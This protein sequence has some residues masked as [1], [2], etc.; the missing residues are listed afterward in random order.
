MPT[1]IK[2]CAFDI[3]TRGK[4]PEFVSGALV[5][6]AGQDYFTDA[7]AMIESLRSYAR[8]GYTL[9][10]HNAEYDV[11]VLLWGYGEDVR[12]D[13][14]NGYYTA[15]YWKYGAGRRRAAIWD[16]YR[17]AAGLPLQSL[18][19]AIGIRKY[20][21]PKRLL[22]PDDVRQDWMCQTHGAPGC[23]I[24]YNI[25]DTEIVWGYMNMLREWLGG[26]GVPLKKSLPSI[27]ME[28]WQLWNPHEQQTIR[29]RQLKQL[30]RASYHGGRCEVY[31]YGS[32][33]LPNTYDIRRYYG[34]LLLNVQ[35]PDIG[36]LRYV[37][38]YRG[39]IDRLGAEGVID[40]TVRIPAQHI[41]P[42]PVVSEQRS[43]FP[44]GE[45][46]GVWPLSE[47]RASLV[48]GVTILAI[49]QAATTNELI[50]PFHRTA[51]VLLELGEDWRRQGDPREILAKFVLNAIIGRLG[52]RD[53]SERTSYRRWMRGMT[54][55]DMEGSDIESADG[56]V[57]LARRFSLNK[58]APLSNSL[59]AGCITALG[60]M[61]LYDH[62]L[63]AGDRLLYCD[64]DSVHT[65]ATLHTGP[66]QPG[67]LVSTGTY[68]KGLYLGPKMYRLEAYDGTKE[69]R[70]KGI[71]RKNADEFLLSGATN[72]QT[73]FGVI[74]A[75]AKGVR[76]S[77]W[78]DVMRTAH[79]APGART[80][81][82]PS[83]IGKAD[84]Q[85]KT[86]P[87]VFTVQGANNVEIG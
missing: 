43:W 47:L 13:Y 2:L 73:T 68:D 65:T 32:C 55:E 58:P 67:Q 39:S 27:A 9:V 1:P 19:L 62:L 77:T 37:E 11:S 81:L 84:R 56:A 20:D 61:R 48:H 6:D 63:Q 57:Y 87:A 69:T 46:R 16:S 66:D 8:K 36:S 10:A 80:I 40:A 74:E 76:P 24:C 3:E 71:P 35:L 26:Y 75:I 54:Q 22:D 28:L 12:I 7:E 60:R 59:W 25:R 5:A 72:Y 49:H 83:V 18:G 85:S 14:T 86:A 42:L 41:P 23:L 45:C 34:S 51:A 4:V 79:Y 64:T 78:M 30:G 44:I 31:Q 52:L 15:A 82:D 70:A 17:L 50:S 53:V 38:N 21:T 33:V 29:S